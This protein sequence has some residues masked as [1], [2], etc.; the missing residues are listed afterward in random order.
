MDLYH[1]LGQ[2]GYIYLTTQ[3]GSYKAINIYK[4]FGFAPY[5]GKYHTDGFDKEQN[6]KAWKLSTK[7]SRNTKPTVEIQANLFM[8]KRP[9]F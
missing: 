3:T 6:E 1:K 9:R 8:Y 5:T 2:K 7:K 4:K